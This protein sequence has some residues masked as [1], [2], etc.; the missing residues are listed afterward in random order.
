MLYRKPVSL[1]Q[2]YANSL[3]LTDR[4]L[5]VFFEELRKRP[6]LDNALVIITGDH[7]VEANEVG[8]YEES[9]RTPL[10][11][12]REG[13][14]RPGRIGGSVHSQMDIAPTI[15]DLL[16]L[17]V[18]LH[19]FQGASVFGGDPHRPAIFIQ[20]YAGVYVGMAKPAYKYARRLSTGEEFLFCLKDDPGEERNLAATGQADEP[21][22][23]FRGC[24]PYVFLN[25]QLIERNRI[26]K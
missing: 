26:W 13:R 4:H 7:G 14:L 1:R 9:F 16:R 24:L 3:H 20:S 11:M 23:F 21:L 2:K 5:P 25:Q 8:F 12:I 19:P 22:A 15:L 18:G 10:L 17:D 6:Y